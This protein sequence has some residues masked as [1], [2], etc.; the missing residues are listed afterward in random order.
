[1]V[2]YYQPTLVFVIAGT[3]VVAC[4]GNLALKD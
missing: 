1:M 3:I 2:V 4:T